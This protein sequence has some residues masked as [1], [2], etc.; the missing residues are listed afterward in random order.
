VNFTVQQVEYTDLNTDCT[1]TVYKLASACT[2][3]IRLS[4]L[5]SSLPK[6][7]CWSFWDVNVHTQ[8]FYISFTWWIGSSL[9]S[10]LGRNDSVARHLTHDL[11]LEVVTD[12]I[13]LW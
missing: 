10:W 8:S 3:S 9:D 6:Q 13:E 11:T 1:F 12:A 5:W 7:N 2:T 4:M